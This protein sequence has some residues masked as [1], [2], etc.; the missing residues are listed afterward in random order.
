MFYKLDKHEAI[1][2]SQH[3]WIAWIGDRDNLKPPESAWRVGLDRIGKIEISTV[4]LGLDHSFGGTPKI[5]ETMTFENDN[6]HHNH[7]ERYSTWNDAD[8]GHKKIC[9]KIKQE[10]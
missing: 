1:P 4:F 2:C 7:C 10:I 3:E 5:F 9:E 8:A 6:D